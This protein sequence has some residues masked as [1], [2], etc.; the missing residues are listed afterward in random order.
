M[1]SDAS[2]LDFSQASQIPPS[3]VEKETAVPLRSDWS[4]AACPI[5]R[6]LDVVGDPWVLLVLREA[7]T[8]ATR[9]EQFRSRAR[10]RRQR[11]GRRLAAMVEAGL[12]DAGA[13]RRRATAPARSTSS[14]PPAPTCSR[15]CTPSRSGGAAPARR[16]RTPARR[17][18]RGLRRG[19]R[20]R[21]HL[22]GVRGAAARRHRLV[23]PSARPGGARARWSADQYLS[24]A[25]EKTAER[26][27]DPTG[28][29]ARSATVLP[30]SGH[31]RWTCG[32]TRAPRSGAIGLQGGD[33]TCRAATLSSAG[34]RASTASPRPAG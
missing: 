12:L 2:S 20:Q 10:G 15:C 16:G 28:T 21:R 6:S 22:H 9:F 32:S 29:P 24:S 7:L 23:A 34:R 27:P 31:V 13:V 30:R 11:A 4:G 26:S 8:G 33:H 1:P 14:P 17:R 25:P 5:A 19:H 18:A 3:T